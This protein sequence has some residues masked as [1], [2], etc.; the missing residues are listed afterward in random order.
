LGKIVGGVFQS[1]KIA[2][3]H[4]WRIDQGIVPILNNQLAKGSHFSMDISVEPSV[5][6]EAT[7]VREDVN[8]E[9]SAQF[10]IET[11]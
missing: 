4:T 5:P 3:S 10:D 8:W 9:G 2:P 1:D 7:K 11:H 6:A